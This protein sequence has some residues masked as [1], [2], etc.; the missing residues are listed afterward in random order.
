MQELA[1]EGGPA[2]LLPDWE[3][4][5]SSVSG[6][7]EGEQEAAAASLVPAQGPP[8]PQEPPTTLVQIDAQLGELAIFGSG[9]SPDPWW[10]PEGEGG[11]GA[12]G[13]PS[14]AQ[15]GA[16]FV[17]VDGEVPLIVLRAS[18]A[19]CRFTYGAPGM[20]G[21][22]VGLELAALL[23]LPCP[24]ASLLTALTSPA[25]VLPSSS[26]PLPLTNCSAH[27]AGVAAD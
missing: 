27:R 23:C 12:A 18:S 16:A 14:S 7:T 6:T 26:S 24:L 2:A 4:S 21:A 3:E 1:G 25:D 17:D 19:T 15:R 22:S 11:S 13:S 9:R 8:A 10:P 5:A 20:T